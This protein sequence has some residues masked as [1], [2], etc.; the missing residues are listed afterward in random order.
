MMERERGRFRITGRAPLDAEGFRGAAWTAETLDA[1]GDGSE[2]VLYT[3]TNAKGRAQAYR[4]VLYVPRTRQAYALRIE[5]A[6]PDAQ[7]LRATWSPNALRRAAAPYRA[8]LHRQARTV[9]NAR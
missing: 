4:L 2:E 9:T 7:T 6:S 3:G 5:G 1:D 8:A